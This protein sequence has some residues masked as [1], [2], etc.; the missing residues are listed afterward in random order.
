MKSRKPTG[1]FAPN[2]VQQFIFPITL[3]T[4]LL[5][6]GLILEDLFNH[7]S[8]N[9]FFIVYGLIVITGTVI[10]HFVIVRTADFRGTYGWLNAILSGIGLGLLPYVVPAHLIEAAHILIPFGVIAVA[11]ISGR[12]YAYLTF[13]CILALNMPYATGVLGQPS[14]ILTVGMPFIL[15]VIITEAVLYIKDA[16]Q[17][18]IHRLETIN[19]VSRQIML[20]LDT[21]Q[22]ISL[23]DATIRETLDADT[24]FVGLLRGNEIQLDLFYDEGQYFNGAKVPMAGSLSGWVIKNQKELFLPDLRREVE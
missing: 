13:L 21:E 11:I 6:T 20:S 14:S 10:N 1:S 12:Q 3:S 22:T 23:L 24:Y 15:S 19:K 5:M 8:F 7:S 9:P 16:T 2:E 17:Q 18:H 4:I